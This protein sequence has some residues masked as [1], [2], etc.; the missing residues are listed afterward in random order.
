[1]AIHLPAPIEI[2][3]LLE[4]LLGRDVGV[5]TAPPL[6]PGPSVP[7]SV[8]VYVDDSLQISAVSCLDLPLSAY[9]AA[10]LGLVPASAAQTAVEQ[11]VLDDTLRENLYE[12]LN[13]AA[14]A[15]N[16]ADAVHVRLYALHPA[17]VALPPDV[18]ARALTLGRRLDLSVDVSGY[19][20]GRWSTVL[21]PA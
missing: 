9:A 6:I 16:V 7:A 2:R 1:M 5:D 20:R 13:I 18:Q 3:E 8:G 19:G 10:S 11:G 14:A 12:V 4:G 17:G 15:F 21:M